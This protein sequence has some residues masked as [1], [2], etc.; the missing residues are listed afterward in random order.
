MPRLSDRPTNALLG[1][2][3]LIDLHREDPDFEHQSQQICLTYR[4]PIISFVMQ[5]LASH[6]ESAPISEDKYCAL[7]GTLKK[8]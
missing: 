4:P 6:G 3:A 1:V 7:V 2:I 8:H 5:W